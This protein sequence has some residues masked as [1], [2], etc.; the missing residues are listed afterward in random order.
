[1]SCVQPAPWQDDHSNQVGRELKRPSSLI[2]LRKPGMVAVTWILTP[3]LPAEGLQ[4]GFDF[5]TDQVWFSTGWQRHPVGGLQLLAR[6]TC[7]EAVHL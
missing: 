1:M 7:P 3:Q 5:C 2:M 4:A 6:A